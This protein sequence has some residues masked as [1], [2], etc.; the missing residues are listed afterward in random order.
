MINND[1]IVPISTVDLLTM[2]ALILKAAGTT[3]TK[4]D[5]KDVNGDFSLEEAPASGSAFASEPVKSFDFESGVSAATVY[6]VPAYDF[7]GFKIDGTAVTATGNVEADGR[8]LYLATLATGAVT[9]TKV[10]L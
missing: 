4:V 3:L 1:R 5:A 10:G 2:Y 6:F 8:T 9:I 7:A